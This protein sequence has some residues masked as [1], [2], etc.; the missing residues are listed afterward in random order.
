MKTFCPKWKYRGQSVRT[1]IPKQYKGNVDYYVFMSSLISS[2]SF[3]D[4][5]EVELPEVES[6]KENKVRDASL[7]DIDYYQSVIDNYAG[8]G[9]FQ[10]SFNDKAVSLTRLRASNCPSCNRVHTRDNSQLKITEKG[11]LIYSCWKGTWSFLENLDSILPGEE[12]MSDNMF[13]NT[14]KIDDIKKN[15]FPDIVDV[16]T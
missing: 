15:H 12:T 11:S 13:I 1:Q 5:M 9:V 7:L 4:L 14:S 2:T 16:F 10:A 3:C 8:D 6:Y